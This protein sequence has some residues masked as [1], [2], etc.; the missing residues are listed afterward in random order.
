M[1]AWELWATPSHVG[2]LPVTVEVLELSAYAKWLGSRAGWPGTIRGLNK[3]FYNIELI[4]KKNQDM[5]CKKGYHPFGGMHF[6]LAVNDFW[7]VFFKGDPTASEKSVLPSC[8]SH[9]K[10][11]TRPHSAAV[12]RTQGHTLAPAAEGHCHRHVLS[13]VWKCPGSSS[14]LRRGQHVRF[15]LVCYS[16]SNATKQSPVPADRWPGRLTV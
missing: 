6:N 13:Q 14:S 9:D 1:D 10:W 5:K 4:K 15:F 16:S 11:V 7:N 2:F 3:N 12:I 8:F